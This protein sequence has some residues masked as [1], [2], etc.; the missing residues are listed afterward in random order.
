M[1]YLFDTDAISESLRPKPVKGYVEWLATV[2]REDQYASAVAIGELFKRAYRS[3]NRQRHLR[4]IEQRVLPRLTVL[5]YDTAAAREYG[6]IRASLEERGQLLPDADIQIAAT[7][8]L[9]GLRLVTGNIKH[10][11]RI[12]GLQLER[13]LADAR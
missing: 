11:E 4:N 5:P 13:A 7:A 12:D 1:A 9:H 2:S 6:R 8:I 3:A 10:F